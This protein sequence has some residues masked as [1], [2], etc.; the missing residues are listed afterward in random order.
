MFKFTIKSIILFI[1]LICLGTNLKAQTQNQTIV[2]AGGFQNNFYFSPNDIDL[3]HIFSASSGLPVTFSTDNPSIAIIVAGKIRPVGVG[4]F[5]LIVSQAGNG[6]FLPAPNYITPITLVRGLQNIIFNDIPAKSISSPNFSPGA[7]A[8]SGLPITYLSSNENVAKIIGGNMI[9]IVGPGSTQI[10]AS[11]EGNTNYLPATSVSKILNVSANTQTITFNDITKNYLDPNFQLNAQ[12]SSGLAISSYTSSDPSVATILSNNTVK[13]NGVGTTTLTA[14]QNGN[15]NFQG[16]SA[17]ATLTVNKANQSILM[18]T[19]ASVPFGSP[20]YTP[21]ATAS[22]GLTPTF[23]SSDL[24]V[25]TIVA[26]KIHVVGVGQ[27]T[28]TANQAGN[29]LFN[30]APPVNLILIVTKGDQTITFPPLLAK[31]LGSPNFDP[32]ATASSGLAVTYTSSDNS[33]VEIDNNQIKINGVGTA[34]ITAT[35]AGNS[36]YNAA[37]SVTRSISISNLIQTI[38]FPPILPKT[39]GDPDFDPGATASSGLAVTYASSDLNV[40]TIVNNRIHLVG[41]GTTVITATQAGNSNYA[42]VTAT[43]NLT[44]AKKDQTI[45]FTLAATKLR[46]DADFM[47]TATASSGLDVTYVSSNPAIAQING[48]VVKLLSAGTVD[49]TAQQ[50]GNNQYNPATPVVKTLQVQKGNQ[51]IVFPPF[52]NK[53][54]LDVEFYPNAYTNSGLAV[55]Y[56]SSNSSVATISGD[57]V[58]LVGSGTS[59]IRAT[60]AGDANW[61][62]IFFERQLN[63]ISQDNRINFPIITTIGINDPDYDLQIT[64]TSGLPVIITSSNPAIADIVGGKLKPIAFGTVTITATSPGNGAFEDAR[65]VSRMV[66][67]TKNQQVITFPIIPNKIIGDADFP[68]GATTNSG[69][70][71]NYTVSNPSVISITGGI[72]KI[73]GAGTATITAIQEGDANYAAAPAVIRSITV[74]GNNPQTIVFPVIPDIPYSNMNFNPGAISNSGLPVTYTTSNASIATPNGTLIKL[75]GIGSVTITAHQAGNSTYAPTSESITVNVIK[76]NSPMTFNAIADRQVH[77]ADFTPS[78]SNPAGLPITFTSSDLNVATIVNGKISL[79]GVGTTTITA[80]HAGSALYNASSAT[81]TLTVT[82]GV[83]FI[84]FPNIPNKN[85][86]S[87]DFDPGA[88]S[89]SSLPITYTSSNTAVATVTGNLIHIVGLGTTQITAS[90]AGNT[91]YVAA[92]PVVRTLVVAKIPQTITFPVIPAKSLTEPPFD[93]QAVSSSGL[94]VVLTSSNSA[95]ASVVGNIITIHT[96]GTTN[97]TASQAGDAAFD[98]ATSITRVLNVSN[99]VQVLTA[100][101]VINKEFGSPDFDIN[102][103]SNANLPVT[104]SSNNP[105]VAI[106]FEGKV[107]LVGVGTAVITS[108]QVGNT[109]YTGAT[110]LTT[111]NVTKTNQTINFPAIPN[112]KMGDLDF[113]IG[114]TAS[115]GLPVFYT[116]TNQLVARII[117]NRIEIVG[118]GSANIIASQPGNNNY[119]RADD[120]QQT[121]TVTK[122]TQTIYF[123]DFP[124][125][126]I[127][128]VDFPHGITVNSGLPLTITSSNPSIATIVGSNIHVV[129][130]GNTT[131]T[132]SQAGNVNFD[133]AETISKVLTIKGYS[134]VMTFNPIADKQLGDPDFDPGATVNTGMP[135]VYTSSNTDVATI[136]NGK[137]RIVGGGTTTITATQAGDATYA[138]ISVSQTFSVAFTPQTISFPTMTAK[139]LGSAD[140]DPGATATSG[141]AVTYTSS[142]PAVATI[143]AGK[144]HIVG[145]GTTTITASQPGNFKFGPAPIVERELVVT[146]GVQTITF[147]AIGVKYH[148]DPAFQLTA[149]ASSGLAVTYTSSNPAVATINDNTVQLVGPGSTI[150]TASQAGN[151]NFAAATPVSQTLDVLYAMPTNNFG[152]KVTDVACKGNTNGIITITAVQNLNYT[153]TVTGN[154]KNIT[155]NFNTSTSIPNLGAGTYKV[156]ITIADINGYSQAYD[157]TIKEPKDLAAF[158]TVKESEKEVVLKLEGAST[159]NIDVNGRIYTTTASEITLPLTKGNNVVKIFSDKI[160]QGIIEKSFLIENTLSIYPNPVVDELNINTGSIDNKPVKVDIHGLDGRLVYSKVLTPA[161]G[162]V[163]IDLRQLNK[164]VYVLSLTIGKDK[165]IHKVVKQ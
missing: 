24:A 152:I 131:I 73:L 140:F 14:Y 54:L 133:P 142:N 56:T 8:D 158:A 93:S 153:V 62:S 30:P 112:K 121:I 80:S 52:S 59:T 122:G 41:G 84:S 108:T 76:G 83:Q 157:I 113:P 35:Q 124:S 141:L 67:V 154:N 160:C 33:V 13:I 37:S 159:Y 89:S 75:I 18:G 105:A 12:A 44:V 72:I 6:T 65:P 70:P 116:S 146:N 26:G 19:T 23:T 95:V 36:N 163:K 47:L 28:I 1:S 149:T 78:A 4:T 7:I 127:T 69:L 48:N 71:I 60:Q 137:V 144:V 106:I 165:T 25:A 101:A 110:A 50:V 85:P 125:K 38:V 138:S 129:G 130:I 39:F 123:P 114:A 109:Q 151:S 66:T 11:Q 88:T 132:A 9:E 51:T 22:S 34:N 42:G 68:T 64:S 118:I 17:S 21:S 134:Q 61:N 147:P 74:T 86:S 55:T 126:S 143:V 90:Q 111:L 97:I 3:N 53:T 136:V 145:I 31:A 57:K 58:V 49:I 63:V 82:Q 81:Q 40:A 155:Q 103:T 102:V 79:K 46:S 100:P 117:G 94:P 120:V 150:I 161:Y 115:S 128:D 139:A 10:K 164:G 29:G 77:L 96:L 162:Q 20:D 98:A 119:N 27:T 99:N 107:R 156:A 43:A 32:G 2:V 104:L 15:T 148:T 92:T 5:N 87:A 16:A 45:G 91:N 135:I